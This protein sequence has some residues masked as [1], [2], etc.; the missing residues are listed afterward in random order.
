[1][2]SKIL[3]RLRHLEKMLAPVSLLE[4]ARTY[5]LAKPWRALDLADTEDDDVNASS[6]DKVEII[7]REIGRMVACDE[8]VFVE[9]LPEILATAEGY[10]LYFFGQGLG[11]GCLDFPKMWQN[12][13]IQLNAIDKERRNYQVLKGFLNA[14]SKTNSQISEKFLDDAVSDN[15]LGCVFPE[16]QTSVEI[17]ES[18]VERLKKSLEL[19]IAPIWMFRN[20]GYGRVHESIND[21]NLAKLLS[22][23]KLKA[24][25][26]AVAIDIL[27]MRLHGRGS[28]GYEP[29]NEITILGQD[30]LKKVRFDQDR[31]NRGHS[32][33]YDLSRIAE[34]CLVGDAA[35]NVAKDLCGRLVQAFGEHNIYPRDYHRLLD[36]IA[37]KQAFAFLEGFLGD[38]S[39]EN[40]RLTTLLSNGENGHSNPLSKISDDVI[41]DWCEANPH[42][43]YPIVASWIT[44]YGKEINGEGLNWVPLSLILIDKAP[45]PI[46]VLNNLIKTLYFMSGNGSQSENMSKCR[47]LL[48]ALKNHEKAVVAEWA[49]E[50][51][52]K[53]E[54]V[55]ISEPQ[56]NID[57]HRTQ[58]ERFE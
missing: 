13:L 42:V 17:N 23:I 14:I 44:P 54:T 8:E 25:G 11:E 35:E 32:I 10:G 7:T 22:L 20:L 43:R 57:C 30:C 3:E 37:T 40:N 5:A 31:R 26:L 36:T 18:G 1:M 15:V 56:L 28:R 16:L 4:K 21:T 51:E 58:D 53:L 24:D 45:D 50:E 9:L 55:I 34:A 12:F 19:D 47:Y 46:K 41:I 39:M 33:G 6:H 38:N 52:R 2:E 48:T 27:T 49:Q 29:S